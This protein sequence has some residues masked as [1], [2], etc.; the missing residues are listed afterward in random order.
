MSKPS[1]KEQ[2]SSNSAEPHEHHRRL[3]GAIPLRG[4]T[5]RNSWVWP[6]L[7]AL[8]L[9]LIMGL[10]SGHLNLESLIANAYTA[11]FLAIVALGQMLVVT[12]GRGA[13]D[14]SIPG[15][16][17]LAA[18][19]SMSVVGGNN[20]MLLPGL[21]LLIVMG[22]FIGFLNGALVIWLRI[23]SIIATMA[24]NYIL[25]TMSLIINRGFAEFNIC[26]ILLS[27]T[28][29]R[30]LGIPLIIYLVVALATVIHLML[31]KTGYGRSLLA[32]G[33]N[34]EAARL[35]R[36]KV[37][38]VELLTYMFSSVLAA[39]AGMLI[40]ARV[41]GAFLG[42]GDTYMLETLASIVIGGTLISGGQ[43]NSA[44][45]LAG[46]L[47]LGLIITA[48]QVM[49]YQVGAQNVAKGALII[50]VLLIGVSGQTKRRRTEIK[51]AANS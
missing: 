31:T 46:A 28:R 17:T 35:A 30:I 49:G 47:F 36:A 50:T 18:Y 5:K 26:P 40:S 6:A 39:I 13:I 4:F 2:I 43:A 23:P 37:V 16:I 38:K 24:M 8:L 45:T 19:V 48:M 15:V 11:A 42:M 32:M 22:A 7:G 14:L 20:A 9:W 1:H 25:I 27:V 41:G 21:G 10:Y 33:Q 34:H 51:P 29:N 3:G 12:T 44:G